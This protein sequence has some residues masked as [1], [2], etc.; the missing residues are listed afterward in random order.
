MS[1]AF[2]GT[3]RDAQAEPGA[4]SEHCLV[5]RGTPIR[6]AA[7]SSAPPP[8]EVHAIADRQRCPIEFESA[9]QSSAAHSRVRLRAWAPPTMRMRN[10]AR[11]RSCCACANRASRVQDAMQR[12]IQLTARRVR[13]VHALGI[14]HSG[15]DLAGLATLRASC[16][17]RGRC[18]S[19][20]LLRS[21]CPRTSVA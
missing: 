21:T 4:P 19:V 17:S 5:E 2:A 20:V 15:S 12:H 7:Q 10:D 8:L 18:Y 11:R 16:S 13:Q 3:V 14:T 1:Q 6:S 9:A